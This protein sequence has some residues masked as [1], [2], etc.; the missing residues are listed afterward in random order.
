LRRALEL[1]AHRS[2]GGVASVGVATRARW[3]HVIGRAEHGLGDL[4]AAELHGARALRTL[5]HRVPSSSLGWTLLLVGQA[6]VQL[7]HRAG[8]RRATPS[9]RVLEAQR[10]AEAAMLLM[11]RYYYVDNAPALLASSLRAVNLAERAGTSHLVPRAHVGAAYLS[12]MLRLHGAAARYFHTAH[13]SAAAMHDRGEQ[14][15]CLAAESVY[16]GTF[17]NWTAAER[18]IRE[19]EDRLSGLEDAFLR[20]MVIT[21]HG[22]VDYFT[23]RF[24]DALARYEELLRSARARNNAQT[25]AWA[26]FSIGRSLVALGRFAEAQPLLEEAAGVLEGRPELQSEIICLGLLALVRL[27]LGD[28]AAARRLADETLARIG[29]ARPTGFPAVVGYAAVADV[30]QELR[31]S[32]AL[33]PRRWRRAVRHLR[34]LARVLPVA[35]PAALLRGAELARERARTGA[36]RRAVLRCLGLAERFGMPLEQALAH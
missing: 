20:E 13:S 31:R 34:R 27:R 6:L 12:G 4:V 3:E 29:R 36:A 1:D 30:Y 5:G 33:L 11:H 24:G 21:T 15:Y 22:H 8:L 35:G 18:A 7:A 9:G 23:G 10:A 16:H 25:T 26:L 14:V 17:G 2:R 32:D 28:G 19:A